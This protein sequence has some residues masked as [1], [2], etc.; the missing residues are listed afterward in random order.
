MVMNAD[1]ILLEL[2]ETSPD[3][4]QEFED[5]F[6]LKQDPRITKIG[7]FLRL[8]SLDEFPQFWNVLKG[9]MSVVGPRPLVAEELPCYGV[10]IE[11]VLTL[12]QE[13]LDCGKFLDGMIFPTTA[14]F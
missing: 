9:D 4:R 2:M 13:L 14:E 11:K 8:T 3:I 10:H 5:N 1:E 7:R 6:K 12:N